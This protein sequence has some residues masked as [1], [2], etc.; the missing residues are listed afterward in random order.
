[1]SQPRHRD[2]NWDM[3]RP[4]AVELVALPVGEVVRGEVVCHHPFGLGLY[5]P[6]HDTYGNVNATEVEGEDVHGPEDFP[7]IGSAVTARV[8]GLNGPQQLA[9]SLRK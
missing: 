7:A 9:L 8:L 2:P 5:L 4:G 6:D 1:M 3:H